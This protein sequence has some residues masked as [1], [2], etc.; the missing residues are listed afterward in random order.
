M[1]I[2]IDDYEIFKKK[3][4]SLLNID[5]DGYKSHQVKRR[6]GILMDKVGAKDFITFY[7]KLE[8]DTY[9]QK[10]FLDRLT[11]NVSEFFRNPE[12]FEM[13]KNKF[14]PLLLKR[15]NIINIWS[16]GCSYGAEPYSVAIILDELRI[17]NFNI[18]A[19]D[20]DQKILLKAKEGVFKSEE[21]KNVSS[22]RLSRYFIKEG[23]DSYR[24]KD[25]ILSAVKF[26][27]L[28]LLKDSY[29][30]EMN[31]IICRNVI[32]YFTQEAR[33]YVFK[34]FGEN[35]KTG[36]ILFLGNTERIFQP[37]RY[38]LKAIELFFYERVKG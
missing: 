28:D 10:E 29:P 1:N 21:M 27:Y 13:L 8:K 31:L 14:I 30:K 20:I 36:G 18:L 37:E 15:F 26:S 35:L 2:L 33:E 17:K 38:G 23:E 19:T 24:I 3:I 16:A 5:L 9:L 22:Q 12:Q 4:R 7:N 25:S 11:I 6:I 32:I 34:N